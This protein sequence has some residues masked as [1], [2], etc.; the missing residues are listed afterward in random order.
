MNEDRAMRSI[1]RPNAGSRGEVELPENAGIGS[2]RRLV[3]FC[4]LHSS[5]CL[6]RPGPRINAQHLTSVVD[7]IDAVPFDGHWRGNTAIGPI[8]VDVLGAFG[9]G[10]LPEE[11]ARLL[12]EAHQDPAVADLRGVARVAIV[13]A[14]VHAAPGDYGRGMGFRAELGGPLDVPAVLRVKRVRQP[15]LARDHVA[16][17]GL[18]KLRLGS[19]QGRAA[20]RPEGKAAQEQRAQEVGV[21]RLLSYREAE[22]EGAD[23]LILLKGKQSLRA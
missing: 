18:P 21:H 1:V 10:E 20:Q 7:E 8:E 14:D 17:P 9:E 11:A 5:F 22:G 3:C 12:V 23:K 2:A 15:A 6:P 13:G 4:I 16:G 19:G